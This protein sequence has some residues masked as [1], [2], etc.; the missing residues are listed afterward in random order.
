M[1]FILYEDSNQQTPMTKKQVLLEFVKTGLNMPYAA[2][3]LSGLDE[4][5][6]TM[7][8]P[9]MGFASFTPE[10]S[11]LK[12]LDL[13]Q[14]D[15]LSDDLKRIAFLSLYNTYSSNPNFNNDYLKRSNKI[16]MEPDLYKLNISGGQYSDRIEVIK[17]VINSDISTERTGIEWE[18]FLKRVKANQPDLIIGKYE[19]RKQFTTKVN[20]TVLKDLVKRLDAVKGDSVSKKD[21]HDIIK[22]LVE[23]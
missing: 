9:K 1:K 23:N 12:S 5:T 4:Y 3:Y 14:F 20:N 10:N 11:F 21:L 2:K 16:I 6:L 13:L 22:D 7:W 8:V 17:K 18:Q 15:N 19:P